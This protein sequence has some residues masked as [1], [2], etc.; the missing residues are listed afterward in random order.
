MRR[1]ISPEDVYAWEGIVVITT[2]LE[3][4][5]LEI[6]LVHAF[7]PD[8]FEHHESVLC[9]GVLF[10]IPAFLSQNLN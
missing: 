2:A 8:L 5:G 6:T 4:R 1:K 7:T 3:E 9:A 10:S